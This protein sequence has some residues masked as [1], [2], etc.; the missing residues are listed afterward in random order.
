MLDP[1]SK[2]SLFVY[3]NSPEEQPVGHEKDW[4][5]KYYHDKNNSGVSIAYNT[6][7]RYAL[8]NDKKWLFLLDQDTEFPED[9]LIKYL[10]AIQTQKTISMFAPILK[11]TDGS[12]TSP[13]IHQFGRRR[14]SNNIT[15]GIHRLKNTGPINSGLCIKLKEFIDAGGY[16]E[17]VKLDGADFQFI[18]R[19][20]KK[21]DFYYVLDLIGFQHLS[22]FDTDYTKI[23]ERFKIYLKDS[24][25]YDQVRLMDRFNNLV[26]ITS[27][28]LSLTLRTK[29]C[30]FLK[31]LLKEYFCNKK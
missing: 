24:H 30:I 29:S 18:A 9:T 1:Y 14:N 20:N 17:K 15:P 26:L 5:I 25:S 22:L 4:D 8:E 13:Y 19:F 11:V 7:A 23:I 27:R 31:Y 10:E 16:N 3:D 28:T 6:A 2:A 21:N 12:I